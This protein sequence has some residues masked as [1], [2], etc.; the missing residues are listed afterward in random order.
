MT[1]SL[2]EILNKTVPKRVLD[3]NTEALKSY[4]EYRKVSEIIDR[5]ESASGRRLIVKSQ[6]GSTR[7]FELNRNGA[8][9]TT[10]KI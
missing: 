9:S 6:V 5:A 1:Q 7:N 2:L 8:T 3:K 10:Q 4:S